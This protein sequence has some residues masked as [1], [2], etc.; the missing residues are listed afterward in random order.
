MFM[1][2]GNKTYFDCLFL[3]IYCRQFLSETFL[4]KKKSIESIPNAFSPILLQILQFLN[5]IFADVLSLNLLNCLCA[6]AENAAR[7]IL[8]Q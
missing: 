4:K 8:F 6:A 3:S 1:L 5:T 2:K 7:F